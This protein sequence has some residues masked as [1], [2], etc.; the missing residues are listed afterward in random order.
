MTKLFVFKMVRTKL[1]LNAHEQKSDR[2]VHN[3][4]RFHRGSIKARRFNIVLNYAIDNYCS[5]VFP[6]TTL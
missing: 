2:K 5:D 6:P 4:D 3:A 1:T